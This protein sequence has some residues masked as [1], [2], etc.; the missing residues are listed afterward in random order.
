MYIKQQKITLQL[1]PETLILMDY[2]PY[3][4][5]NKIK[6]T[7]PNLEAVSSVTLAIYKLEEDYGCVV[8]VLLLCLDAKI[9]S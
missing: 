9:T 3:Y 6:P 2:Q 4:S 7:H 8:S 5:S 1:T